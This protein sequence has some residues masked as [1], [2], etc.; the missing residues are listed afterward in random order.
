MEIT[1]IIRRNIKK[2]IEL[3]EFEAIFESVKRANVFKKL[4]SLI[5]KNNEL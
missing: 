1:I 4:I 5:T 2:T 3:S